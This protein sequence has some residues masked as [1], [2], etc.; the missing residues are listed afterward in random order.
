[1]T[2]GERVKEGEGKRK[3]K[4]RRESRSRKA[5]AKA[6]TTLRLHCRSVSVVRSC[7]RTCLRL[8]GKNLVQ[9]ILGGAH[10]GEVGIK[11]GPDFV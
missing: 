2:K 10:A 1:M 11:V 5:S 7:F 9:A 3:V 6:R 8:R 4:A